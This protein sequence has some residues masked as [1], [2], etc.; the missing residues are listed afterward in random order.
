MQEARSGDPSERT[1]FFLHS[2]A[3]LHDPGWGHPDHQGRLRALTSLVGRDLLALRGLVE[4]LDNRAAREEVVL[5]VHSVDLLTSLR[6]ACERAGRGQVE[7]GPETFV[8]SASWQAMMG[9]TGALL[10]AVERVA[11]GRLRNAFVAARPPGHHASRTRSMGFCP[12]NHV[13]IAAAHLKATGRAERVAIV[14]WDV[15]HGNGT[16]EIFYLDPSVYYLSLH[17]SPLFPGTGST[18]EVGK[19]P[20]KGTTLNVPLPAGTGSDA[21]RAEFESALATVEAA[22]R[23]DLI[24]VSAGYDALSEDPLGGLLLG[25]EDF[26]HFTTR[27]MEWADR[28]CEGRVV[29]CL[30]GG[31]H[32]EATGRAV[33]ATIRALAGLEFP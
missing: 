16:Q 11:D 27:V 13:A 8:S 30:E 18:A 17:Q 4:Q 26:H 23:P 9:S 33:V 31:Y 10:E 28:A 21:Y 15:H 19:G 32:P 12:I 1:G 6:E 24:L 2:A 7:V 14:D 3:A 5:R 20:G 29:A 22:F 25:P